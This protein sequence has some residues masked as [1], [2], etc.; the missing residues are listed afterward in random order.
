VAER[1]TPRARLS[2]TWRVA[3]AVTLVAV[4]SLIHGC[5]VDRLAGH[6]N[7]LKADADPLPKR[8][9][10]V[11]VR[12]MEPLAP[13]PV[14]AAVPPPP[15][16]AVRSA[17]SAGAQA[18]S[19]PVEPEPETK[20]PVLPKEEA[21]AA[22]AP[23]HAE[24]S[25]SAVPADTQTAQAPSTAASG[26][27][28]EWPEGTRVSF[29]LTG[30][31][32]GPIH[33]SAQVEWLRVEQRYQVY[34]DVR[35]GPNLAPFMTRTLSSVGIVTS[36]GLQPQTYVQETQLPFQQATRATVTMGL[37]G[38]QLANGTRRYGLPGLHDT[39]S[40]FVQ[41]SWLLST[42]PE[43]A[44][45][46]GVIDMPLAMPRSVES[47]AY[48]VLGL[49]PLSTPFGE[50]EVL[51]LKPRRVARAGSDMTLEMWLSPQ[52]RYLP[53]RV[54]IRQDAETFVDLM[55]TKPPEV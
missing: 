10:A 41:L 42:Q 40:Q 46:G 14:A 48:D 54:I 22:P 12:S 45:P 4:V 1:L 37:D 34:L 29:A 13:L 47:F 18:A 11:Y 31:Y 3:A 53:M 43:L 44:Q 21:P 15:P 17:V 8:M 35:V 32:K 28:F 55:I 26:V 49:E 19:A 50:L 20:L 6:A 51:H 52:Y 33:G 39:A 36:K 27:P 38:V 16:A 9:Q 25:A 7:A 24:A 23:S 5:L 2:G 30:N